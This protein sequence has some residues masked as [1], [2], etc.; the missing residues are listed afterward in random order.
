MN[1][2]VEITQELRK[3]INNRVGYD[4][5]DIKEPTFTNQE[6]FLLG[7]TDAHVWN[8]IKSEPFMCPLRYTCKLFPKHCEEDYPGKPGECW[9]AYREWANTPLAKKEEESDK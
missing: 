9:K 3:W 2:Y 5:L 7:L 1:D 6:R 8:F 4:G